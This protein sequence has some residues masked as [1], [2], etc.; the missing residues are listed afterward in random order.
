MSSIRSLGLL[1]IFQAPFILRNKK[2]DETEIQLSKWWFK[3]L[4]GKELVDHQVMIFINNYYNSNKSLPVREELEKIFC[5]INCLCE[6]AY[7]NEKVINMKK[8]MLFELGRLFKNCNELS[9]V[10]EYEL[11]N[12]KYPSKK[13]LQEYIINIQQFQQDPV[14]YFNNDKVN[15]PAL[16][17]SKE[18]IKQSKEEITEICSLCFEQ[19]KL[20][21]YYDLPCKHKFHSNEKE[22]L[23]NAGITTWFEKNN[24]C[25]NCKHQL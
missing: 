13:E 11:L 14:T 16:S 3:T 19:I 2:L 10:Y 6:Y 21:P 20:S 18:M 7:P 25:P 12:K 9:I 1:P 4:C 24:Y 5:C 17:F 22:C 23:E 15:R 8:H